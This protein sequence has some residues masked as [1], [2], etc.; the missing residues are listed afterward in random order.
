MHATRH[1][2]E[3]ESDDVD[4]RRMCK[5]KKKKSKR[6]WK[7]KLHTR[8]R[9]SR[10]SRAPELES[11]VHCTARRVKDPQWAIRCEWKNP[12]IPTHKHNLTLLHSHTHTNTAMENLCSGK[13]K[14]QP[15]HRKKNT[16]SI[17]KKKREK[18]NTKRNE[19]TSTLPESGRAEG[20]TTASGA[21]GGRGPHSNLSLSAVALNFTQI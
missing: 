16:K 11:G 8:R 2:Y 15:P 10:R 7:K 1:R 3:C 20:G 18:E 21:W 9:K 6:N 5:T 4:Q 13:A 12:K 17:K 19:P 14:V